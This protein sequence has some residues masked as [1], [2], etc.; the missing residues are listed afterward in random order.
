MLHYTE[1]Y[2]C[3]LCEAS[4]SHLDLEKLA[5]KKVLVTGASGLICSALVDQLLVVPVYNQE[6]YLDTSVPSILNQTYPDVEVVLVDDGSTDK[7]GTMCDEYAK[8][9][10]NVQVIH[11]KNGGL[12]AAVVTGVLHAQGQYY[13]AIYWEVYGFGQMPNQKKCICLLVGRL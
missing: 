5:S 9:N 13:K 3:D 11:Q 1:E 7:S 8:L 4:T 6:K 10:D 2:L 12:G